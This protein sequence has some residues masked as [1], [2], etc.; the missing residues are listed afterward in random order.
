MF[1]TSRI[2]M[3][4]HIQSFYETEFRNYMIKVDPNEEKK[5]T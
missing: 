5:V 4:Q 3:A 2:A 1:F